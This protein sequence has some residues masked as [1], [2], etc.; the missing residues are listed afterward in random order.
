MCSAI[1][2][3]YGNKKKKKKKKKCNSARRTMDQGRNKNGTKDGEQACNKRK[4]KKGGAHT[5]M[6]NLWNRKKSR[7]MEL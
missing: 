2:R 5:S 1:S 3:V 6:E 7:E 4:G